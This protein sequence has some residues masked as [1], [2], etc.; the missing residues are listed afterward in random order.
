YPGTLYENLLH[1]SASYSDVP[2]THRI[3]KATVSFTYDVAGDAQPAQCEGLSVN[4]SDG[5]NQD[6]LFHVG[7]TI[8]LRAIVSDPKGLPVEVMMRRD[9]DGI[10]IEERYITGY[11]EVTGPEWV[12]ASETVSYTIRPEDNSDSFSF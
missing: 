2:F 8:T 1:F 3:G 5:N 10:P 4:G 12:G 7:E 9:P 11:D 6:S